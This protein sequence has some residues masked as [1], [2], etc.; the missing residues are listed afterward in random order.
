VPQLCGTTAAFVPQIFSAARGAAALP[1][2]HEAHARFAET[3]SN[4]RVAC[5]DSDA[6]ALNCILQ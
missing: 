2:F 5:V 4:F 1:E 3:A 6:L